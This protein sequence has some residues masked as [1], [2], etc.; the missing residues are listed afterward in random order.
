[1]HF[2]DEKVS[3]LQIPQNINFEEKKMLPRG[4]PL[5]AQHLSKKES[6]KILDSF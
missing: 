6:R 5:G 2:Q 1:M 3:R 4:Y